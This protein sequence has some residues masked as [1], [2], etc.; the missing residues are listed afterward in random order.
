MVTSELVWIL[1]IAVVWLVVQ[2]FRQGKTLSDLRHRLKSLEERQLSVTADSNVVSDEIIVD[3]NPTS[4]GLK[5][6]SDSTVKV[7][8]SSAK[9][10]PAQTKR[11][12]VF[13][14]DNV[15]AVSNWLKEKW[16]YAIAAISLVLAGVFLVQ[17]GVE[18]G[19]LTPFWRVVGALALGIALVG[20]GEWVRR[21]AS[22]EEGHAAALPSTLSGAGV[23]VMFTAVLAARQMY[24]LIGVEVAFSGLL[25]VSVLAL[26]L[27]WF[28]GP[29]LSVV[30]L[31]GASV[32][33]FLVGGPSSATNFLYVYFALVCLVGLAIDTV[34]RRAWVSVLAIAFP[35]VAAWALLFSGESNSAFFLGF[36]IAVSFFASVVPV[37]NLQPTHSGLSVAKAIKE[38]LRPSDQSPETTVLRVEFPTRLAF[39]G[40]AA[41]FAAVAVVGWDAAVEAESWAAIAATV[42]LFSYLNF[43]LRK[44]PALWDLIAGALAVF[45]ALIV[46]EGFNTGPLMTAFT[47][48]VNRPPET[49]V[50]STV[51]FLVFIGV[52]MSAALYFRSQTEDRARLYW[53]LG[54][55]L[56]APL[57]II[58]LYAFWHPLSVL[59]NVVWAGVAMG[60][61]ALM[62]L[63]TERTARLDAGSNQR[64]ALFATAALGMISFALAVMLSSA[65]LTISLAVMVFLAAL[66]DRKYDMWLLSLFAQFG[67]LVVGFRYAV[68]PGFR[69]LAYASIPE[70]LL[71]SPIILVLLAG[72]WAALGQRDRR[73]AIVVVESGFW[74]LLAVFLS[75]VFLRL[76]EFTSAQEE[77]GI[78][79]VAVVMWLSM[80]NQIYRAKEG[81]KLVRIVRYCL[82]TIFGLVGAVLLAVELIILNPV[83]GLYSISV[84]GPMLF[85][86]LVVSYGIPAMIFT[87]VTWKMGHLKRRIR[88]IFGAVAALGAI[89]F[90]GLEIRHAWR[91]A[92]ME[93]FN[94]VFDGELYSY[95]IAMLLASAGLLFF[96]FSKRNKTLRRFAM[97]G[98]GM[99]IAKVFLLDMSG[100]DG[101]IRVASF[102]GL[103]LSLAGLAWVNGNMSRQ[104]DKAPEP[105]ADTK[106]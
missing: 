61:A 13:N 27:G 37:R 8:P 36:T 66:I 97:V 54:S 93:N 7:W 85:N 29:F 3:E 101:L 102:L 56:A 9:P 19:V 82:A 98:I 12:F 70:I 74:S 32:A 50:P 10:K 65:A 60:I 57:T 69:W 72:A 23:V 45:I 25:A 21:R 84:E 47:A 91:G 22:D 75:A 105:R 87:V 4:T 92:D 77:L 31:L 58:S 78:S 14:S 2:A 106:E 68:D 76:I 80:A 43:G 11:S 88:R 6:T 44:A 62:V 53:A 73:G 103:G 18:N 95:T 46:I 67:V 48:A 86:S 30:G 42:F 89:L 39:G 35:T 41:A 49:S 83:W 24:G 59:S 79:L 81:R 94:G 20:G 40:F 52:M 104:W 34:R 71:V 1:A 26:V 100:L 38:R 96:A 15:L 55:A 33:P 16:F 5:E 51:Y 28:Y 64:A 63:F 90:V 99:T 17:Y